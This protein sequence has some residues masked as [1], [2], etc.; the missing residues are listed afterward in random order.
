MPPDKQ[1]DLAAIAGWF[2]DQWISSLST[3]I[4]AMTEERPEIG[5][6][7]EAPGAQPPA[8]EAAGPE[9]VNE[10]AK[11]GEPGA[12]AGTGAPADLLWWGQSFNFL[13]Q[14]ALWIRAEAKTR[15]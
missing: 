14:P 5:W 4:E 12:Q 6:S 3:A 11:A 2:L 10:A 13:P 1:S 7:V 9:V 15:A 8:V